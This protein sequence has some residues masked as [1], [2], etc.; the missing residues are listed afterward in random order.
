M[1]YVA[2][3]TSFGAYHENLNEHRPILSATKM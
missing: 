2:L 3:H 1:R